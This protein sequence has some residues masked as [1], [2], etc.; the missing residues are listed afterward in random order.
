MNIRFAKPGAVNEPRFNFVFIPDWLY[1]L[2]IILETDDG[3]R[4]WLIAFRAWP[5]LFWRY[6][7]RAW[8]MTHDDDGIDSGLWTGRER[9]L[10][11]WCWPFKFVEW[12]REIITGEW[13]DFADAA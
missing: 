9:E 4:A 6:H 2:V 7:P 5:V 13:H 3:D 11:S 12:R 10:I 1:S 8:G